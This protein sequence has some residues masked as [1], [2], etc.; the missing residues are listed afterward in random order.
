MKVIQHKTKLTTF[1]HSWRGLKERSYYNVEIRGY[2]VKSSF[3]G[4][5]RRELW[6]K[7]MEK[8]KMLT[9]ETVRGDMSYQISQLRFETT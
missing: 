8:L 6:Y 3:G 9:V 5:I 7:T 2:S 4:V 1:V